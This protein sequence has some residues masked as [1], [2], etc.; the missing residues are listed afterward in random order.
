MLLEVLG[1]LIVLSLFAALIYVNYKHYQYSHLPQPPRDSF[2]FGHA[3]K[4]RQSIMEEGVYGVYHL[5]LVRKYGDVF[6][7]WLMITPKVF[8]T[9]PLFLKVMF[10]D[11]KRFTRPGDAPVAKIGNA[12]L[13]GNHSIITDYGGPIWRHKKRI[14][15]PA[16]SMS[17]LTLHLA[18][19][20]RI[21]VDVTLAIEEAISKSEVIDI[22]E[23]FKPFT[24]DAISI[25]GFSADD[26]QRV[27]LNGANNR[28]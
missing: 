16:F 14:M 25:A 13:L 21:A 5:D 28:P 27:K 22:R 19:F 8:V 2:I 24:I 18:K 12:R 26:E 6:C 17:K 3:K 15:D 9:D 1:Y 10:S 23:L 7:Y 11:V 4:V 20:Q